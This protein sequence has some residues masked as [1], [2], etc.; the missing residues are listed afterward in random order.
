MEVSPWMKKSQK[1]D[2]IFNLSY[3]NLVSKFVITKGPYLFLLTNT[4]HHL[5]LECNINTSNLIYCCFKGN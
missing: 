4:P 2:L 5:S 1:T 3:F